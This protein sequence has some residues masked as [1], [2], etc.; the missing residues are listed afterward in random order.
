MQLE[1]PAEVPILVCPRITQQDIRFYNHF[2]YIFERPIFL[3]KVNP[4]YTYICRKTT[5]IMLE[6]VG[7]TL[8]TTL[9]K[10]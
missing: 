8:L 10:A 6:E 2:Y 1:L 4:L 5:K 3:L 7:K 9:L